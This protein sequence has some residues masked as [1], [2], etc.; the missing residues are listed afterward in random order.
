M[1]ACTTLPKPTAVAAAD[2]Y[3]LRVTFNNGEIRLFNV[4][5]YLVYPAFEALKAIGLF[6]QARIAHNTVLWNEEV[7]LAPES[8]YL[9]SIPV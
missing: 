6:M 1:N 2:D 7:D 8:L 5:P 9:E 3:T 4:T